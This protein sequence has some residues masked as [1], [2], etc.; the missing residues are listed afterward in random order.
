AEQE[1]KALGHLYGAARSKI[2]VGADAREDRLKREAAQADILHF[3]THGILSDSSPMYSHLVFAQGD[4]N[5]DGVLEAWE[6][7]Q[8]DLRAQLGVLSGCE[9]ARGRFS[10]GEGMIGLTW[11]MF[12]AGVP[13]TV[14]SQW[15]V[16]A[17]STR[18]LLLT[19]H[20]NLLLSRGAGKTRVTK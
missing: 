10:A 5:E 12:V 20:R 3:A 17:A 8:L 1:V 13:T 9:S 7:M 11:A 4:G 16:E 18:D 19:F 2:Y 6:I 14:V 15:K